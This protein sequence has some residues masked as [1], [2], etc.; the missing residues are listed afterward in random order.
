VAAPGTASPRSGRAWRAPRPRPARRSA[1]GGLRLRRR[2][3]SPRRCRR[4]ARL[5]WWGRTWR[6][7]V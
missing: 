2:R 4:G 6:T 1:L 3:A 7:D 5:P